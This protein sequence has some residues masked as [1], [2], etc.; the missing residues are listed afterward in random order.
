MAR[1]T[2][3]LGSGVKAKTCED[4]K[5][6]NK[7][8]FIPPPKTPRPSDILK[9]FCN[10]PALEIPIGTKQENNIEIDELPIRLLHGSTT[11]TKKGEGGYGYVHIID[12]HEAEL[13]NINIPLSKDGII[14]FIEKILFGGRVP[15]CFEGLEGNKVKT[16]VVSS[17]SG[18]VV[19]QYFED[20]HWSVVTAYR[21]WSHD[22]A[23]VI[24]KHMF[25]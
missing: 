19:L 11:T 8:V 1:P 5:D 13:T 4:I 3:T 14:A 15:I 9:T 20:S 7:N 2:L 24:K 25:T 12:R 17:S 23:T 18:T 10:M 21:K 16:T 6:A 22:P